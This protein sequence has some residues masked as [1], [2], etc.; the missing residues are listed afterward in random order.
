MEGQYPPCSSSLQGQSNDSDLGSPGQELSPILLHIGENVSEEEPQLLG[1]SIKLDAKG[2]LFAPV[3]E[4]SW[5]PVQGHSPGPDLS[6]E[7][8]QG[9]Q[10]PSAL[11]A[12]PDI[13]R[14]GETSLPPS[15]FPCLSSSLAVRELQILRSWKAASTKCI[16]C[17]LR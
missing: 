9:W 12:F 1:L 14:V 15:A 6:M 3:G 10:L 13:P 17:F 2:M 7:G 8:L 5:L 11:V 4:L 16:T